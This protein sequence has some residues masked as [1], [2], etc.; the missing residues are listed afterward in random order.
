[1]RTSVVIAAY[2]HAQTLP[3][4][5]ASALAQTAPVEVIVVD[6]GST[7]N[8]AS[9]LKR[10]AGNE[11]VRVLG[12]GKN[13][14]VAE[15]RNAGVA[16]SSGEFVMFLDADDTI[17]STKVA[18][19][20]ALLDADCG[21]GW[22]YCDVQI[23]T[24]PFPGAAE[25]SADLR[26]VMDRLDALEVQVFRK[27][28][29]RG[30]A[31]RPGFPRAV[32]ASVMYGYAKRRLEGYLF[33][34]IL[35]GNFIPV[36]A[37]L[38]RRSVLDQAGPFNPE[39]L[40]E[41]WDLWTRVAPLAR[42]RYVPKVLA[43]YRKHAGS[44][45]QRPDPQGKRRF[46]EPT[47]PGARVLRLHVRAPGVA[48]LPGYVNLGAEDGW[49]WDRGLKG[50]A[51]ES[52]FDINVSRP[53]LLAPPSSFRDFVSGVL[54]VLRTGGTLRVRC[55]ASHE[56]VAEIFSSLGLEPHVE[57]DAVQGVKI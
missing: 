27:V 37:P 36:H 38:V 8:T 24:K 44:R 57:P 10:Y 49:K 2:N 25:P 11:R 20:V 18:L 55:L 12:D 34:Q 33:D 50:F 47:S 22:A 56:P 9:V 30:P 5:V 7:D 1:M 21:A 52:V 4:A 45:S 54:R 6:D 42:A 28:P 16:A 13:H 43:T 51:S 17:E 23:V 40:L 46:I 41:D 29:A 3:N 53:D 39:A 48:A 31:P 32:N 15:A 26:S 35:V 19:Q 14:G